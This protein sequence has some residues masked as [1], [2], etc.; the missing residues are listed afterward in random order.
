M[1]RSSAGTRK[2][3]MVRLP[4]VS[5]VVDDGDPESHRKRL[6]DLLRQGVFECMICCEE[7]GSRDAVWTCYDSCHNIFHLHCISKWACANVKEAEDREANNSAQSAGKSGWRCPTCQTT[8][9][10]IPN[11]YFCFCGQKRNPESRPDI[12]PH[13]CGQMCSKR[14]NTAKNS[15]CVHLCQLLCHPGACPPCDI[16]ITQTC[17]CGRTSKPIACGATDRQLLTC[18]NTCD[19]KL[20][21]QKHTCPR[22]CHSGPCGPCGIEVVQ[23][24]FCGREQNRLKCDSGL[25]DELLPHSC[26]NKC[27]KKLTCG[28]HLCKDL[29]HD[30]PCPECKFEPGVA[31]S[32]PCGKMPI[33]SFKSKDRIRCTD[34]L[35]VCGAVC[36]KALRCGPLTDPHKCSK[37]CHNGACGPCKLKTSI[38]CQCAATN[39]TVECMTLKDR[40]FICTRR[41][42]K[43]MSCGRHKCQKSCCKKDDGH[44]CTMICQKKLSCG[45]H[46]CPEVCHPGPCQSCWNVSWQELSCTCGGETILPPISCGTK[47]PACGRTCN[48]VH[49]CDHPVDHTCHQ[50]ASCPPCTYGTTRSCFGDHMVMN[51]VLCCLPG[52]SCGRLCGKR[53]A[54]GLHVCQRACHA[55]CCGD[56]NYSCTKVRHCGHLCN[57]TCHALTTSDSCPSVP[58][59]VMLTVYCFCRRLSDK[60]S[61]D[62]INHQNH[63]LPMTLLARLRIANDSEVDVN[64]LIK[65]GE[66]HKFV[67]LECDAKCLQIERNRSLADALSISNP[68]VNPEPGIKYSESLKQAYMHY[69][70]FVRETYTTLSQLV[71]GL[72][73]SRNNFSFHNF[74]AMRQDLRVIVHELAEVF[75]CKSHSE[76]QEPNRS[77]VVKA[78]KESVVP[79]Q[80]IMDL[81]KNRLPGKSV[82]KFTTLVKST[83][84]GGTS[85]PPA[86]K[87]AAPVPQKDYFDFDGD[88]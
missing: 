81:M 40:V 80:S 13:S 77:V 11:K 86:S 5:L 18:D 58:C 84:T 53:M 48:R 45:T 46:K 76:D 59:R 16:G 17:C 28:H 3:D 6:E 25:P 42:N 39:E 19:K 70:D 4:R 22:K 23:K 41:C 50:D 57:Q 75:K 62:E 69:P 9:E 64:T 73:K 60:R 35:P 55:G 7:I 20:L 65:E 31:D 24:C 2:P 27:H 63:R 30:G 21:C 34:P 85:L 56:C 67:R 29:C 74:P 82:S 1:D 51:N 10:K 83:S 72:E 33:S 78:L 14:K 8:L 47:V 49:D 52:V 87:P 12:V 36:G 88:D 15:R 54:C 38:Q 61:C 66:V 26:G 79:A 68:E 37:N 71:K 32:C 44:V 43:K